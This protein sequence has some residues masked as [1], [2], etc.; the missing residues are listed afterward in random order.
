MCMHAQVLEARR[1]G[2][3]GSVRLLRREPRWPRFSPR[4]HRGIMTPKLPPF[5]TLTQWGCAAVEPGLV[6]FAVSSEEQ[7]AGQ[8]S[9][10]DDPRREA[11][12]GGHLFGRWA[13]GSHRP[14]ARRPVYQ[15]HRPSVLQR[16]SPLLYT[17][18]PHHPYSLYQ[19]WV[20]P[21]STSSTSTAAVRS[22]SLR[23]YPPTPP[24]KDVPLSLL[25]NENS[26]R[27]Y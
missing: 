19:M 21:S 7:E 27:S 4:V 23:S 2:A 26:S 9:P 20:S 25:T 22:P 15:S 14:H 5:H 17:P 13:A 10:K 18:S 24:P 11:R 8:H 1:D 12:G 16:H 6:V 3:E